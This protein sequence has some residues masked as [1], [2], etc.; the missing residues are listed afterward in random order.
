MGYYDEFDQNETNRT[1]RRK[2]K[3]TFKTVLSSIISGVVGGALVLGFTT[4]QDMNEPQQANVREEPASEA[5]SSDSNVKTTEVSSKGN[6]A[7]IAERLS[8]TIVGITN[9]QQ[10]SNPFGRGESGD[11]AEAGTGTGVIF[12]KSGNEAFIVTNNHVIEGSQQI[13]V[14]LSNGEKVKAEIVGA[15]ALTDM[16]VLKISAENVTTVASFGDSSELRAGENVIA[17]GNPLGLEFS[18]TVTEGIISGTN[19]EITIQTSEGEWALSV[20]QTD[21]AINPGNSGGPLI[22]MSGEVIGINSLKISQDGV[23]GLGFSIPSNDVLSIV[24]QLMENGKVERPFLGVGLIDLSEVPGY[25]V[26]D[27]L[28]LPEEVTKGVVVGNLAGGS[29]ADRA[30]L[31]EKDVIVALNDNEIENSSDLRKYLYT[32]TK[33]GDEIKVKFYRDGKEQTVTLKL[34]E[35]DVTGA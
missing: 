11:T 25:F 33:V 6:I 12:K 29:P 9:L 3:G 28:K 24:E 10:T 13:E 20:L 35:K 16:A 1:Y 26:R 17:I 30:G 7:D 18:R 19:R 23:E 2:S 15:D 22:N 14:T 8:P 31:Q 21:A 32:K 5:L 27:N 4:Y 34:T